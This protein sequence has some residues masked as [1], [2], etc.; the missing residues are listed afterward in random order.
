MQITNLNIRHSFDVSLPWLGR[1]FDYRLPPWPGVRG[2]SA[3]NEAASSNHH[4]SDAA[5]DDVP[6]LTIS[7]GM[8]GKLVQLTPQVKS[9]SDETELSD[10]QVSQ[11]LPSIV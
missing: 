5:R 9:G 4:W 8:G 1:I 10:L 3:S 11:P 6:E 2:A 7:T